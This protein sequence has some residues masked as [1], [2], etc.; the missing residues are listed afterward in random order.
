MNDDTINTAGAVFTSPLILN[1]TTMNIG[2]LYLFFGTIGEVVWVLTLKS[3]EGFT[4]LF[5]TLLNLA[6]AFANI[7]I[8][9]YA[10][11]LLPTATAY[12]IWVGASVI[13]ISL[14]AVVLQGEQFTTAKVLW[15]ALII[16]GIAGLKVSG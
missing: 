16:T 3:T 7:W 15:I 12:S 9:S 2:W 1:K 14:L 11:K 6:I 4:R 10:F 5:P 8:L 13:G